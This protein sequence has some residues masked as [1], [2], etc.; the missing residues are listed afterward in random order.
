SPP[1]TPNPRL[2]SDSGGTPKLAAVELLCLNSA[3]A[4]R[5]SKT[6]NGILSEGGADVG[7]CAEVAGRS[8]RASAGVVAG[9]VIKAAMAARPPHEATC[10]KLILLNICRLSPSMPYAP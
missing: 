1:T 2:G 8:C 9:N 4:P 7:G 10:G 5:A 3:T 6:N